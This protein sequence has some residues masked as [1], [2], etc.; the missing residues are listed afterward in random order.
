ML[1][2]DRGSIVR[3]FVGGAIGSFAGPVGAVKCTAGGAS[4]EGAVAGTAK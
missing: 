2:G 4:T 3:A 1:S